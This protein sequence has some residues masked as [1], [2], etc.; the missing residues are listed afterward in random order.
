MGIA[1]ADLI[2]RVKGSC[3]KRLREKGIVGFAWQNGYGAFSV[4]TCCH[5]Y[6][7]RILA[8]LTGIRELSNDAIVPRRL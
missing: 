4:T 7:L 8:Q 2:G 6:L 3:S 5:R 1:F